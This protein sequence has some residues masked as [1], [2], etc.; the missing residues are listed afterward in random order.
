MIWDSDRLSCVGSHRS[1]AGVSLICLNI[2]IFPWSQTESTSPRELKALNGS[3]APK[4]GIIQMVHIYLWVFHVRQGAKLLLFHFI[5][6]TI[7]GLF[8]RYQHLH[9]DH[10]CLFYCWGNR[11]RKITGF[12]LAKITKLANAES[13]SECRQPTLSDMPQLHLHTVPQFLWL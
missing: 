8:A 2:K 12:Y 11:L 4:I 9:R 13:E 3:S 10:C 5:P 6:R 7:P 1:W